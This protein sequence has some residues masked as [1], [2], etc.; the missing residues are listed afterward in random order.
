MVKFNKK[1]SSK[2]K[3]FRNNIK[4]FSL[5]SKLIK[6][7][8]KTAKIKENK[9]IKINKN[10]DKKDLLKKNE[11]LKKNKIELNSKLKKKIKLTKKLLRLETEKVNN[12]IEYIK[13]Q[14]KELS[15]KFNKIFHNNFYAYII[16]KNKITEEIDS[17]KD[18]EFK[19]KTKKFSKFEIEKVGDLNDALVLDS[20]RH[21]VKNFFFKLPIDI[22]NEE[23]NLKILLVN[24]GIEPNNSKLNKNTEKHKKKIKQTKNIDEENYKF[25]EKLMESKFKNESN[26]KEKQEEQFIANFE[27]KIEIKSLEEFI[28]M[29]KNVKQKS[30][31]NMLYKV[32]ICDERLKSKLNNIF[33][34]CNS[35]INFDSKSKNKFFNHYDDII[36]VY[37][38]NFGNNNPKNLENVNLCL[39]LAQK[40]CLV[41]NINNKIF[42][43]KFSNTSNSEDEIKRNLEYL[44]VNLTSFL[45]AKSNKYNNVKAVVIR[46]ENSIPLTLYGDLDVDEIEYFN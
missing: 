18:Q 12:A 17:F 29:I 32:I 2:K 27:D 42:K 20:N 14:N 5:D 41:K 37:F 1:L 36:D 21:K 33:S 22:I 44:T 7:E 8:L 35:K 4:N 30:N 38:L 6:E 39:D 34:S 11:I 15:E 26:L 23:N 10:K 24:S 25:V 3:T 9:Q 13:N 16:L 28:E 45:L 43:I 19:E 40:R 31:L 46:S